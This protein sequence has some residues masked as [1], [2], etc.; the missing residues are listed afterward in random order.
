MEDFLGLDETS[1][2]LEIS[3]KAATK[4][5]CELPT[6]TRIESIPLMELLTEDIH[7]N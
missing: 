2:F 5:R 3:F 6:G 1:P 4:L 7:A